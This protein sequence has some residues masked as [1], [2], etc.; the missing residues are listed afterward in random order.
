MRI[1]LQIIKFRPRRIDIFQRPNPHAPQRRPTE[2][3]VG[4]Q[5]LAINRAAGATQTNW[6]PQTKQA[7]RDAKNLKP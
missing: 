5:A 1:V 6:T 7:P 2:R 4:M 3:I